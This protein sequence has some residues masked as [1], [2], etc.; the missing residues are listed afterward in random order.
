[1]KCGVFM[2]RENLYVAIEENEELEIFFIK[3]SKYFET[4]KNSILEQKNIELEQRKPTTKEVY[5]IIDFFKLIEVDIQNTEKCLDIQNYMR[6]SNDVTELFSNITFNGVSFDKED[7]NDFIK[8]YSAEKRNA[9]YEYL[10]EQKYKEWLKNNKK[11]QKTYKKIKQKSIKTDGI[12]MVPTEIEQI[13]SE[14]LNLE[15]KVD[16]LKELGQ[17]TRM[18][19]ELFDRM[20]ELHEKCVCFTIFESDIDI[21]YAKILKQRL[22][23]SFNKMLNESLVEIDMEQITNMFFKEV[24]KTTVNENCGFRNIY[25]FDTY[26]IDWFLSFKEKEMSELLNLMFDN[27]EIIVDDLKNKAKVKEI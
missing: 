20:D 25:E 24:M 10:A 19:L 9:N 13:M 14:G 22:E 4:I 1:M 7:I 12:T 5:E 26:V 3:L 6:N 23:E 21:K 18:V 17:S 15:A 2:Y 8:K 11:T 27:Y 16:L